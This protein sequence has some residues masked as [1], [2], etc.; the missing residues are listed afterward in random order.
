MTSGT[1][2]TTHPEV[3]EEA[4]IALAIA[5][6]EAKIIV[7]DSKTAIRNFL[8][9]RISLPAAKI[10]STFI[11]DRCRHVRLVWTPAH[12]SLPGNELAHEAARDFGNQAD[13]DGD[14]GPT[15]T[16]S[17]DRLATYRE[18][19]HHYRLSRLKYPAP[20]SSLNRWQSVAWRRIQSNTFPNP[21]LYN[22]YY[23]DTYS[24][25]CKWCADKATLQHIIW[26]CPQ[27]PRSPNRALNIR[28][29]E[30]WEAALLSSHPDVQQ[31][32]VQLAEDAARA[33]GLMAAI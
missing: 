33:H 29:Q 3:A 15:F 2:L 17:R 24:D 4:A 7:S 5:S 32:L 10:L 16:G 14:I 8:A 9:G 1:I 12:S 22:R 28:T 20:H 27:K 26:A 30:Q 13:L 11:G 31:L 19:T 23:P 6:T 25:R 18:I 21:V